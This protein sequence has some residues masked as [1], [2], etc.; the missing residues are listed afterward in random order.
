MMI[1]IETHSSTM[2]KAGTRQHEHHAESGSHA[3]ALSRHASAGWHPLTKRTMLSYCKIVKTS[4]C[5]PA[6]A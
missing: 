5:Q 4:G 3:S 1:I 2:K 6:L